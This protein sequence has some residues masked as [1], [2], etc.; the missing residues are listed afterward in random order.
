MSVLAAFKVKFVENKLIFNNTTNISKSQFMG[1]D[2]L[3]LANE[4]TLTPEEYATLVALG[5]QFTTSSGDR[6]LLLSSN[7]LSVETYTLLKSRGADEVILPGITGSKLTI[8]FPEGEKLTLSPTAGLSLISESLHTPFKAS[9]PAADTIITCENIAQAHNSN[10]SSGVF[11]KNDVR[12]PFSYTEFPDGIYTAELEFTI[13]PDTYAG[14][15]KVLNTD[16]IQRKLLAK[17]DP[18]AGYYTQYRGT[19]EEGTA[20]NWVNELLV[21]LNSANLDFSYGNY[22]STKHKLEM[23]RKLLKVC[24]VFKC[25]C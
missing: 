11:K 10:P 20:M 7:S 24:P 3:L 14:E 18:S 5:Y 2:K 9:D 17:I 8:T 1:G 25:S 6:V 13:L 23:L 15:I 12:V 4:A 22:E 21:I 19:R 16:N